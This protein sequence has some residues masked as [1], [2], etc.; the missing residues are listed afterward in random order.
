MR[1]LMPVEAH[2]ELRVIFTTSATPRG[3]QL[4]ASV[5]FVQGCPA[6]R[7]TFR[8]SPVGFPLSGLRACSIIASAQCSSELGCRKRKRMSGFG[9]CSA[10]SEGELGDFAL[11][12][13][14]RG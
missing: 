2:V 12:S 3:E 4:D 9:A 11:Q 5:P 8:R 7:V 6:Q 14:E 10:S 13:G 1:R